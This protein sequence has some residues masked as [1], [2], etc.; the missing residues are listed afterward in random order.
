MYITE[1]GHEVCSPNKNKEVFIR[2]FAI[3]HFVLSGEGYI[4]GRKLHAN[5]GFII[6]EGESFCYYPDPENPWSYAWANIKDAQHTFLNYGL[7]QGDRCFDY[8]SNEVLD[9]IVST[10]NRQTLNVTNNQLYWQ[11]IVYLLLSNIDFEKY[12]PNISAEENYVSSALHYINNYY[13]KMSHV[14]EIAN[15]LHISR[16]Y[17]R[18]IFAKHVG[19]SPQNYLINH[20]MSR[21][22]ELLA[23]DIPISVISSSVGYEDQLQF[24]KIFKKHVGISPSEYRRSNK[25][26]FY[27]Q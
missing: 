15:H 26:A 2:D 17:L 25:G 8:K 12:T 9:R 13:Y 14:Q 11:G 5:Q 18:N 10:Y 22:K 27:R 21:A 3:V 6:L 16:A 24:S 23:H 1:I 20:R 7:L 19:M 4:N